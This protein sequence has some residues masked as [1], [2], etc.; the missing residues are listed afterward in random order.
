[1]DVFSPE[2]TSLLLQ[3]ASFA[4]G[5]FHFC[6]TF[7]LQTPNSVSCLDT[8]HGCCLLCRM[9]S[10]LLFYGLV[11]P[12]A[13]GLC[14]SVFLSAWRM[15]RLSRPLPHFPSIRSAAPLAGF[16]PCTKPGT[17][18]NCW[19]DT[20]TNVYLCSRKH[21]DSWELVMRD[22]VFVAIDNSDLLYPQRPLFM[23]GSKM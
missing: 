2:A 1:M 6:D 11:Q 15:S 22:T 3:V 14:L 17:Y 16:A 20:D 9:P 5:S 10:D 23:G 18:R 19:V 7:F 4:W 12:V 13:E 8:R 21:V